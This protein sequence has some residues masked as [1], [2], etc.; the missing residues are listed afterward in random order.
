MHT[1]LS[2][3]VSVLSVAILL[4]GCQSGSARAPDEA[5]Q[6]LPVSELHTTL[7]ENA[8]SRSGGPMWSRWEYAEVHRRDGTMTGRV[9][10]PGGTEVAEGVWEI[11]ADGLYCRTWA[12]HWA[13]GSRGCFRT[14][15]DGVLL[16]FDHV[17]GAQ[18]DQDRYVY[19]VVPP[20]EPVIFAPLPEDLE[21]SPLK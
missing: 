15:R 21:T 9:S 20:G 16:V 10:W 11:S 7:V 3:R 12:N 14:S 1:P 13:E 6:A 2:V 5:Q 18:G 4:S 17:S 8:L 19:R